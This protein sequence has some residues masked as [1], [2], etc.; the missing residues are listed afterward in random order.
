MKILSNFILKIANWKSLLIFFLIYIAF[1]AFFFPKGFKS[2]VPI[3]DQN[4]P[5]LDLQMTYNPENV[6]DIVAMYNGAAKQAYILSATITDGI[7]PIVYFLLFGIAFSLVFYKWR[8]NPWFKYINILP[9]S[10]VF[11]DYMENTMIVQMLKTAPAD[12]GMMP[13]YCS[14]FTMIKWLFT[15]IFLILLIAGITTN[16]LKKGKNT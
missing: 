14:T 11:F 8:I 10:I 5:I 16:V 2:D 6:K 13:T 12:L 9:L 7:Y 3:A 4:L 15:T 1:N